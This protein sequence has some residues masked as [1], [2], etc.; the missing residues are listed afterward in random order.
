[1]ALLAAKNSLGQDV[2]AIATA[3]GGVCS[4]GAFSIPEL[5]AG[6]SYAGVKAVDSEDSCLCNT[7]YYSLLSACAACQSQTWL[8]WSKFNANCSK[9]F[10][11]PDESGLYPDTIPSG[12]RVPGW[13]YSKLINDTFDTNLA[14]SETNLPESTGVPNSAPTVTGQT[15][16]TGPTSGSK[17]SNAGAIAGGVIGGLVAV[18]LAIGAAIIIIR[19]RRKPLAPSTMV[20][21]S[22]DLTGT[23][24]GQSPV[25]QPPKLYDP[26]DPTTFPPSSSMFTS[27]TDPQP[28]ISSGFAAQDPTLHPNRL[29]PGVA[30]V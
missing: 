28:S 12:T 14:A 16:P 24:R 7:V 18:A 4:P 27:Y 30:E 20:S 3:V 29:H 19:R 10:A 6:E 22:P 23:F 15:P 21:L 8:S 17:K 26:S 13:A 2:C 1:M 9:L 25:Y 5:L 11:L